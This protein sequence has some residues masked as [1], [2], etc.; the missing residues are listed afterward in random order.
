MG[1]GIWTL[2][3]QNEAAT[4]YRMTRTFVAVFDVEK[5]GETEGQL[6]H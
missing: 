6:E 2:D 3:L 5:W 1:E 4:L